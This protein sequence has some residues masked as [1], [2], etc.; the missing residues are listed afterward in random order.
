[1][2]ENIHVLPRVPSWRGQG[3]LYLLLS[4]VRSKRSARINRLGG[5]GGD[6]AIIHLKRSVFDCCKW[7]SNRVHCQG[8]SAP[9][10]PDRL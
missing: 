1:M 5:G 4:R 3:K 6:K 9:E 10:G 7:F 2:S 8:T